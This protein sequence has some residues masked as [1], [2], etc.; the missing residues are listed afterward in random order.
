MGGAPLSVVMNNYMSNYSY[1]QH[2]P[3][4]RSSDRCLRGGRDQSGTGGLGLQGRKT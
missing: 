2:C 4:P 1:T 3:G